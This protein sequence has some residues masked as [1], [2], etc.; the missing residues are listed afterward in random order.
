MRLERNYRE[1]GRLERLETDKRLS[2]DIWPIIDLQE[3]WRK[4]KDLN[5]IRGSLRELEERYGVIH[6]TCL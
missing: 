5:V 4:L 1:L 6:T 3:S 2:F